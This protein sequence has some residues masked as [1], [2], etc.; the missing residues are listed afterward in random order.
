MVNCTGWVVSNVEGLEDVVGGFAVEVEEA[1][2][3]YTKST[4]TNVTNFHRD[5]TYQ[6]VKITLEDPHLFDFH[7]KSSNNIL[8]PLHIADNPTRT[9]NHF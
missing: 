2:T 9:I 5:T 7:H 6:N 4:P 3:S 8:Q 1:Y